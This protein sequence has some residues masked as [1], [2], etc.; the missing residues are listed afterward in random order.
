[1]FRFTMFTMLILVGTVGA[2]GA[3]LSLEVNPFTGQAWIAN[4]STESI[5]FDGYTIQAL[6]G[7][8][9]PTAWF[10][11]QD[12]SAADPTG[13]A[14]A[15]GN[16]TWEEVAANMELLAEVNLASETL[17]APGFRLALGMPIAD[18]VPEKLLF[19]YLDVALLPDPIREV[20][21]LVE[22]VPEPSTWLLAGC[23][24]LA[25]LVASRRKRS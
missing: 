20:D 22:V 6:E 7:E 16:T 11:F 23:G 21:G 17:A 18:F 5:T 14:A 13:A 25:L 10:S 3:S 19:T 9:D 4:N 2:R 1:M 12:F 8:L 24:A 15:L